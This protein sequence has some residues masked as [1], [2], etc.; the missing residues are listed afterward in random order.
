MEVEESG[1]NRGTARNPRPMLKFHTVHGA[2]VHLNTDKT[3]ARRRA[4]FFCKGLA[5]SDRP[6]E[7]DEVVCI[8][9]AETSSQWS[10]VMRFGLTNVDPASFRDIELP[11]FACP[12]LTQKTGY[13]AKALSERYC[14][15]G[16][17]LHFFVNRQGIVLYGCNGVNKGV[18]LSDIDITKPLWAIVDIYGNT[19][20]VEFLGRIDGV[21][22]AAVAALD[23]GE[24]DEVSIP[25]S[26]TIEPSASNINQTPPVRPVGPATIP[27]SFHQKL[28]VNAVKINDYEISRKENEFD[29]A[30]CF[31]S[32]PI[33]ID[34]IIAIQI[35]ATEPLFGGALGFGMTSC[36][37]DHVNPSSLP[38]D[39]DLLLE[40]SEY[41]VVIKDV[42]VSPNLGDILQFQLKSDGRVLFSK[43]EA[44]PR[45]IMHMDTS[46]DLWPFFDIFGKTKGIRLCRPRE[47]IFRRA[48]TDSENIDIVTTPPPRPPPPILNFDDDFTSTTNST[49]V[50]RDVDTIDVEALLSA[51][52]RNR[53]RLLEEVGSNASNTINR[54]REE[55]S[56]EPDVISP[57]RSPRMSTEDVIQRTEAFLNSLNNGTA[58]ASRGPSS[59]ITPVV[60]YQSHS[61]NNLLS[62]ES[63][64]LPLVSSSRSLGTTAGGTSSPLSSHRALGST[65]TGGSLSPTSSPRLLRSAGTSESTSPLLSRPPGATSARESTSPLSMSRPAIPPRSR[66]STPNTNTGANNSKAQD[67]QS[68]ES[69]S[70]QSKS[71][72]DLECSICLAEKANACIYR[73]GHICMCMGCARTLMT[74]SDNCPMC[75]QP[76][77][78]VLQVFFS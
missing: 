7:I 12:D 4:T 69:Q 14:V 6:I 37:P 70:G 5:F 16:S 9:V 33:R 15:E 57:R 67:T 64:L 11:K 13:W 22:R 54:V 26:S 24:D 17:I 3:V 55:S 21:T 46:I 36:N 61:A 42:A 68:K 32:R 31:L 35:Q 41:W 29:R 39:A 18:F 52:R 45:P 71:V 19:V 72:L 59:V 10:G 28:G 48:S 2:N 53:E 49:T 74:R 40:R 1:I 78:D 25:E 76:I 8:R 60:G 73:C 50:P 63:G 44:F 34:E 65:I 20:G 27:Y 43:N 47:R 51:H 30:Y 77:T 38:V 62:H 56:A 75:R 58:F 23:I 66:E